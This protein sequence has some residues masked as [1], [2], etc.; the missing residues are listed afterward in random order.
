MAHGGR[1]ED[2]ARGD[3][4]E[5]M[6]SVDTKEDMAYGGIEEDTI[7][8]KQHITSLHS[9]DPTVGEKFSMQG[10]EN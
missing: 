8:L 3:T 2:R 1:V 7:E 6:T 9:K 5:D 4:K 10:V